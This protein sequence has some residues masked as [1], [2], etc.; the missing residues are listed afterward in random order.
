MVPSMKQISQQQQQQIRRPSLMLQPKFEVVPG[1]YAM[2]P[3]MMQHI[4]SAAA[5]G[6]G[7][8]VPP[9][10]PPRSSGAPSRPKTEGI[11]TTF[12]KLTSKVMSSINFDNIKHL[13]SKMSDAIKAT[14]L[15][16]FVAI[17]L[18]AACYVVGFNL[19]KKYN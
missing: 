17:N 19:M 1:N 9:V 6:G 7:G 5:A 2:Q 10:A 13:P 12:S 15:G 11:L 14:H 18:A 4:P 16:P 8:S 3:K